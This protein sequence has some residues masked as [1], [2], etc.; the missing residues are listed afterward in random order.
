MPLPSDC[1]EIRSVEHELSEYDF[2]GRH[3]EFSSFSRLS[4]LCDP[5]PDRD[6][7]QQG[8]P[9]HRRPHSASDLP[10]GT[11]GESKVVQKSVLMLLVKWMLPGVLLVES[12]PDRSSELH[13][14]GQVRSCHRS[15]PS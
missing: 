14:P 5:P 13:G 11:R 9:L 15:T 2:Q 8:R 4:H 12:S 3:E 6:H 7:L 1:A 10:A